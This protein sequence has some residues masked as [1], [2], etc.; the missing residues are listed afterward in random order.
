[1]HIIHFT[2]GAEKF[3]E[4]FTRGQVS[5]ILKNILFAKQL[6]LYNDPRNS[7][8]AMFTQVLNSNLIKPVSFLELKF[9]CVDRGPVGFRTWFDSVHPGTQLHRS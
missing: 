2:A 9:A 8:K 5:N 7:P 6:V 1:M 4:V 3:Q